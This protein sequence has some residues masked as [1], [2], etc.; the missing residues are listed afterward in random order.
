MRKPSAVL[1]A[2]LALAAVPARAQGLQY[3]LVE[4]GPLEPGQNLCA[5][6][7]NNRGQV[8]GT[9]DFFGGARAFLFEDGALINLG[10]LAGNFSSAEDINER[11]QIVGLTTTPEGTVEAVVIEKGVF[12]TLGQLVPGGAFS[13]ATAINNRGQIV[14]SARST[15]GGGDGPVRAF[16]WDKGV[17]INL[18]TLDGDSFARDINERGDVVGLFVDT[19]QNTGFGFL[20]SK[21]VMTALGT[22][23]GNFSDAFAIN[24]RGQI[25]GAS[26]NEAGLLRAFLLDAGRMIDLGTLGGPTSVA[27]DINARGDVVGSASTPSGEPHAFL[28]RQGTLVDLNEVLINPSPELTLIEANAINDRGEIAGCAVTAGVVRAFLLEPVH[29]KPRARTAGP[30]FEPG[31]GSR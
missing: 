15:P 10:V 16:L 3:E 19:A 8:V 28:W 23:G 6:A 24:P 22:L 27:R 18:G 11:G 17:M 7:V 30:P 21:G 25:V 26:T 9:S 13:G 1:L 20:W 31:R 2:F 12:Q 5:Q 29:G 14:G 4:I